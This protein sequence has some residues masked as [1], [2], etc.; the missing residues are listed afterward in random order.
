MISA[1]C[2][3]FIL[4]FRENKTLAKIFEFTVVLANIYICVRVETLQWGFGEQGGNALISGERGIK[5]QN[6][7][8]LENSDT[9]GNMVW[10]VDLILYVPST[11]FQLYRDGSSWVEPVLS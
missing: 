6:W 5:R 11:I 8:K 7:C 4:K 3:D 9:I 10:L 1:F 2:K